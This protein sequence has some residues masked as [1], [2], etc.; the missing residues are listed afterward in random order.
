M[1][2]KLNEWPKDEWGIILA[3]FLD[4]KTRKFLPRDPSAE[5]SDF[6]ELSKQLISKFCYE[7]QPFYFAILLQSVSRRDGH[8]LAEKCYERNG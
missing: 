5:P 3:T 4:D 6:S 7:E 1:V 8:S 2:A